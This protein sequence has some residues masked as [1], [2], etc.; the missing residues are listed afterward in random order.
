MRYGKKNRFLIWET[1]R[2]LWRIQFIF[3]SLY[4]GVFPHLS[5]FAHE[6]IFGVGPRTIWSEGIGLGFELE[7][8]NIPQALQLKVIYGIT[9]DLS[10]VSFTR[11]SGIRLGLK[12]RFWKKDG[13]GVQD[14]AAIYSLVG[15]PE[16]SHLRGIA[17]LSA[18]RESRR[19]YIFGGVLTAFPPVSVFL[20]GAFGL[21]PYLAEYHEPD[22]VALFEVLSDTN[23]IWLGPSVFITWRNFAL[24]GGALFGKSTLTS[25]SL[26]IHL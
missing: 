16:F 19:I 5:A 20:N 15:F 13:R 21:R 11:P 23:S 9:E 22:F 17:G 7:N 8:L 18:G 2:I 25:V 1:G 3:L 24:R 12:Y 6:P 14:S 26:E 4:F 10:F